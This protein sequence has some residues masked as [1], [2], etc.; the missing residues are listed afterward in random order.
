MKEE[1]ATLI[2]ALLCCLRLALHDLNP[3]LAEVVMHVESLLETSL[4]PNSNGV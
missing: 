1:Q 4:D 2:A 3:D